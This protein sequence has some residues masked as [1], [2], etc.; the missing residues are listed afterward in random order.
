MIDYLYYSIYRWL[1]K[2]SEKDIAEYTAVFITA[3][4][5]CSNLI[6]L[7]GILGF[8]HSAYFSTKVYGLILFGL[9]SLLLYLMFVRNK[10]Y[11]KLEEKF[12]GLSSEKIKRMNAVAVSFILESLLI[13]II[14]TIY[15]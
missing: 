10:R 15:K 1:S 3:V 7:F 8:D 5:I 12:S 9:S 2:T 4:C 11:K 13:I 6:V 14:G